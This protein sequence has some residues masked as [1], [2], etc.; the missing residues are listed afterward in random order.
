MLCQEIIRTSKLTSTYCMRPKGHSGK[1]YIV[2]K[3]PTEEELKALQ[4]EDTHGQAPAKE[5]V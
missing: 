1:H 2:D 4:R 5:G 3:E